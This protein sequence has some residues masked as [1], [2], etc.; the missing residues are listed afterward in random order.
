MS[1]RLIL[2]A[3]CCAL[4]PSL[5]AV[6][7]AQVSCANWNTA[8]FFAKATAEDVVRCI[9]TGADLQGRGSRGYTPLHLAAFV[10]AADTIEALLNAGADPKASNNLGL[11]PLDLAKYRNFISM[12]ALQLLS[13]AAET[14]TFEEEIDRFELFAECEPL[15]LVVEELGEAAAKIGLTEESIQAAA[16]SRLRSARLY[17]TKAGQGLYINANVI[18][19]AFTAKLEYLKRLFDPLSGERMPAATWGERFYRHARRRFGIHPFRDI[20]A[21][22]PVSGRIPARE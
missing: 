7:T 15:Q 22:G 17:S 3:A 1:I 5:A 11:T 14:F 8:T 21:P 20:P 13:T 9:A 2:T 19:G 4:W 16:E 6:E 10:S 18:G 12:K